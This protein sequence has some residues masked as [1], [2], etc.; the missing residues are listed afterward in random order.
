MCRWQDQSFFLILV[1]AN[2]LF[3][4]FEEMKI[5]LILIDLLSWKYHVYHH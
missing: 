5:E 3:T 4:N 1:K 2:I